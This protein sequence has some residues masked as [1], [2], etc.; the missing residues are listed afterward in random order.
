[1]QVGEAGGPVLVGCA[2][3]VEMR[4]RRGWVMA[5]AGG[6]GWAEAWN[7]LEDGGLA[8]K[9]KGIHASGS[10]GKHEARELNGARERTIRVSQKGEGAH[11][12]GYEIQV[13]GRRLK[14]LPIS[15]LP[16]VPLS[17]VVNEA[18]LQLAYITYH[19]SA[20]RLL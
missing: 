12:A 18:R 16:S 15:G 3:G 19:S 9:A 4:G 8:K 6:M 13:C 20:I 5:S 14:G 11:C 7:V 10:C 17:P 2:R 1:M